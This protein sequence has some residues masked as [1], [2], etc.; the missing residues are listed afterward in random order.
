MKKIIALV[1]CFSTH[2]LF[3]SFSDEI[4]MECIEYHA[5]KTAEVFIESQSNLNTK[6]EMST[7]LFLELIQEIT[8]QAFLIN[9]PERRENRPVSV[10]DFKA[11][12]SSYSFALA[13]I[14]TIKVLRTFNDERDKL[15]LAKLFY[16]RVKSHLDYGA[17][18]STP[19]RHF[20]PLTP[21]Q[22]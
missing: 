22:E 6:V 15:V 2:P 7:G 18:P 11:P 19:V 16:Q 3:C 13:L 5:A 14:P 9:S 21:R 10:P 20:R 12:Q 8:A 17:R 1:F 4:R